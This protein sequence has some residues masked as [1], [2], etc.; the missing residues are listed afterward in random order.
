MVPLRSPERLVADPGPRAAECPQPVRVLHQTPVLFLETDSAALQSGRGAKSA[1]A[2]QHDQA[3]SLP[4]M[5]PQ[6]PDLCVG[7]LIVLPPLK[8]LQ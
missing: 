6:F 1:V 3:A 7:L 2:H 8:W 4:G 5:P